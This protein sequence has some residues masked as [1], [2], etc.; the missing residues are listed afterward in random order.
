MPAE[1]RIAIRGSERT[2]LP[3]ARRLGPTDPAELVQ[4]TVVL[5]RRQ[6]SKGP[7]ASIEEMGK[8][9]PSERTTPS[10]EEFASA[11]GADPADLAKVEEFAHTHGLTVVESS[12]ARRSVLLSGTVAQMNEA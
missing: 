6:S 8:L 7:E 9:L 1:K 10:R 3:G 5:R 12:A 2:P 11:H 4:V